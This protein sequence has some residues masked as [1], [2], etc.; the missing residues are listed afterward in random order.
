MIRSTNTRTSVM[1]SFIDIR[2]IMEHAGNSV[3]LRD[4]LVMYDVPIYLCNC[5][6]FSFQVTDIQGCLISSML[7]RQ[8]QNT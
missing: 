6:P 4:W 2:N 5:T 3:D 8:G 1:W 7:F